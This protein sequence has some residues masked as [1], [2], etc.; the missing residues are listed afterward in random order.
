MPLS[1]KK[2]FSFDVVIPHKMKKR[3]KCTKDIL[4]DG[5][6]KLKNQN[7]EFSAMV[8]ELKRQLP[9]EFGHMLPKNKTTKL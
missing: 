5:C 2:P 3:N 4:C 8:I 7:K 9:N 6:D 1:W